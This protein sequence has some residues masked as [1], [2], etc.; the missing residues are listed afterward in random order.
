MQTATKEKVTL[1]KTI[2]TL[3]TSDTGSWNWQK[4]ML[5]RVGFEPTRFLT[6]KLISGEPE[7]SAI[8]TRP[9]DQSEEEIET[10]ENMILIRRT[11]VEGER[12]WMEK[13]GQM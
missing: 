1:S 12:I 7:T 3:V 6:S 13:L 4:G 9:S 8:T 5:I 11:E 10:R 2:N